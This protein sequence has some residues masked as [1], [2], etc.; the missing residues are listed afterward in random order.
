MK[1]NN[2]CIYHGGC[3]DGFGAAWVVKKFF[4]DDV[5]FHAAK[6]DEPMPD[7]RCKDVILV[8]FSYKAP[9]LKK[10]FKEAKSV[11]WLDH[12]KTAVEEWDKLVG[13]PSE[14]EVLKSYVSWGTQTIDL[15]MNKSGAMLAWEHFFPDNQAPVMIRYIEDR[16]LWRFKYKERTK[17]FSMALRSYRYSFHLWDIISANTQKIV[18]EGESINRFY[19]QKINELV[20]LA[21]SKKI[22]GVEALC[23]NA[24]WAFASDLANELG[25]SAPVGLTFFFNKDGRWQFSLRSRGDEKGEDVSKIS[26]K[27]GGGGHHNAAGFQM[28]QEQ[29]L[30]WLK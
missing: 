10:L 19:Q 16:D 26:Q 9:V 24:P 2:L 5:E 11:V 7:I 29:F 30:R 23:V 15:D 25:K 6:Y 12:H 1:T 21:F 4:G 20:P 13:N 17:N 28:D 14:L 8:D 18:D 22:G 27:M 3:D